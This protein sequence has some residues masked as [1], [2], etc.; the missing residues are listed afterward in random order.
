MKIRVLDKKHKAYA[1]FNLGYSG[2]KLFS[3]PSVLECITFEVY[4]KDIA[5]SFTEGKDGYEIVILWQ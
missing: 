5:F 4:Q 1:Y 2:G 3:V